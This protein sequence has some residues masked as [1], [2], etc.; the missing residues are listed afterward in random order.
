[1]V[2]RLTDF[3]AA[4]ALVAHLIHTF[5][6]RQL[7]E[8]RRRH[9]LAA[10]A[11]RWFH[12]KPILPVQRNLN[13]AGSSSREPAHRERFGK[14]QVGA[15]DSNTERGASPGMFGWGYQKRMVLGDRR[16]SAG[17]RVRDTE[18][19]PKIGRASCR[20]RV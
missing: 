9:G 14:A 11:R 19:I 17:F 18:R 15:W 3:P 10:R 4:L 20:E 8:A 5:A 1:M 12:V 13:R 6:S 7:H 16:G 2:M